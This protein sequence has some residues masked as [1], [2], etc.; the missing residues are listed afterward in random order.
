MADQVNEV[1]TT[2]EKP[3]PPALNILNEL[4]VGTYVNYSRALKEL[5]RT[6]LINGQRMK[7]VDFTTR[8]VAYKERL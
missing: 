8:Q 5:L 3:R 7:Q 4:S 6:H 2:V 1:T